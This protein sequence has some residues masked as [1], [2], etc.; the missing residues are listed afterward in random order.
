MNQT[1][2]TLA[3]QRDRIRSALQVLLGLSMWDSGRCCTLQ[4]FEFGPKRLVEGLEG[5]QK[6]V[7]EYALHVSACAWRLI[8]SNGLVVGSRDLYYP[9]APTNC[10]ETE[11]DEN[12]FDWEEGESVRDREFES[13]FREHSPEEL[14][15]ER[16]EVDEAGGFRLMLSQQY[17][18]D[19][20]P[21]HRASDEYWRLFKP[22]GW[23]DELSPHFV[24]TA[25]GNG[26]IIKTRMGHFP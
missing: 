12:A 18:L 23:H 16:I 25:S 3:E 5:D 9:A 21:D 1:N 22:G 15:V 7:G 26:M 19:V 13:F 20:F 10:N 4:W 8:G 17:C 6:E 2:L 11:D 14:R 24:V